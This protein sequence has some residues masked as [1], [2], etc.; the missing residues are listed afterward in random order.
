MIFMMLIVKC[1]GREKTFKFLNIPFMSQRGEICSLLINEQVSENEAVEMAKLTAPC[2]V[3]HKSLPISCSWSL[4]QYW[5][6]GIFHLLGCIWQGRHREITLPSLHRHRI[7]RLVSSDP[8]SRLSIENRRHW[9]KP[10][11][12]FA[13]ILLS[14]PS[15]MGGETPCAGNTCF[16]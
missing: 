8:E 3:L 7:T 2:Q 4:L 16:Y 11:H 1:P 9:S 15:D 10:H 14:F 6:I 13:W 12:T 5:H